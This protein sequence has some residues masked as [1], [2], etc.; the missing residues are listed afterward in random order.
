MRF[1]ILLAQVIHQF[2]FAISYHNEEHKF[3][4]TVKINPKTSDPK[5]GNVAYNHGKHTMYN[6]KDESSLILR[7]V[8]LTLMMIYLQPKP[9]DLP[10]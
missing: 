5:Y 10:I 4:Q 8:I 2:P 3:G 6:D 9:E 1:S 7:L